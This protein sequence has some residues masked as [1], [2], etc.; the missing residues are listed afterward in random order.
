MMES[1]EH[2]TAYL[3]SLANP[4]RLILLCRL[5]EGNARVNQLEEVLGIPQSQVSKQLA[6]LRDEGLVSAER[7]GRSVVYSLADE[8]A[9]RIVHALYEEFCQPE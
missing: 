8:K 7:D 2:T 9:R 5:S 4:I 3:K 6:R 1:A